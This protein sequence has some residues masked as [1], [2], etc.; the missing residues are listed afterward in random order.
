MAAIAAPL[1]VRELSRSEFADR[2]EGPGLGLR[3]GPFDVRVTVRMP[4][5]LDTLHDFYGEYPLLEGERC[6]SFHAQLR[7]LPRLAPWHSR[8]VRFTVD[9]RAPHADMPAEHALAVLEWGFNLV[10]SLRFHCFMMFHAAVV[11]RN[12]RAMLL[13]AAPGSGKTT[14]CGALVNSGWRL[15]SDEFGLVRPGTVLFQPLP[16]PLPL[17][18]DS[19][20]VL[21]RYAPHARFG[22]L[23]KSTRKGDIVHL[24]PPAASIAESGSAVAAAWIVFPQ[25]QAQATWRLDAVPRGTAFMSLAANAFNYELQGR[26]GFE[27]ARDIIAGSD[28]YVLDY[29]DLD[30]AVDALTRLADAGA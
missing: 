10:I 4:E 9:G 3:L 18:N 19:I 5:L 26:A 14:L 30:Q 17:K 24:Y 8:R 27:T 20:A 13:P 16:R 28:A 23:Q 22:P 21:Q 11:E 25:W 15:L 29:H 2:M 6:F 1:R 12:G 7:E